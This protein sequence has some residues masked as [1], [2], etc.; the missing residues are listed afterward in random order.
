MKIV[1]HQKFE[2]KVRKAENELG[3]MASQRIPV[4]YQRERYKTARFQLY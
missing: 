3:I 4:S 1:D 2:E